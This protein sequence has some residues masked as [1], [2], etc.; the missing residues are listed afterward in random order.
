MVVDCT[1]GRGLASVTPLSERHD[2]VIEVMMIPTQHI[3]RI[4]TKGQ[5]DLTSHQSQYYGSD[6][7]SETDPGSKSGCCFNGR[8]LV[9]TDC[10]SMFPIPQL[11]K[12]PSQGDA[13]QNFFKSAYIHN[14]LDQGIMSNPLPLPYPNL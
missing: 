13:H 4:L 6:T 12:D 5:T 14:S 10:V 1:G 11:A 9:L 8:V 7:W 2:T 3:P